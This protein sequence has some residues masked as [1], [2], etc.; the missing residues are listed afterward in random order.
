VKRLKVKVRKEYNRRIL[1]N[2]HQEEL[3]WL[4]KQ[5]LLAKKNGQASFLR[6]ILKNDGKGRTEFYK[7]VKRRKGNME[8]IA[9]IKEVNRWFITDSI[10]KANSLNCHYFSVF[11][12][13]HSISQIRCANSNA[14]YTISTKIIRRR[15]AVRDKKK[16]VWPD[17]VSS[18]ILKLGGDAMIP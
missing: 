5:L 1:V 13:E 6:S 7:Y 15:L 14:P 8:D 9:A 10:A 4:S 11:S 16:S 18:Q 12:R 2:Q 17:K 3:K